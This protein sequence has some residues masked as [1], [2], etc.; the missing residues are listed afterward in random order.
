MPILFPHLGRRSLVAL[1]PAGGIAAEPCSVASG[2]GR[3]FIS[4]SRASLPPGTTVAR[5]PP[6][7]RPCLGTPGCSMCTKT[8]QLHLSKT[9]SSATCPGDGG[10]RPL[11]SPV[12]ASAVEGPSL[13]VPP[14]HRR[15]CCPVALPRLCHG[16]VSLPVSPGLC[17]AVPS[18]PREPGATPCGPKKSHPWGERHK[19]SSWPQFLAWLS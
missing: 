14:W 18:V 5:S 13:G 16:V 12:A 7:P 4:P 1:R 19:E 17:P 15:P 11:S 6:S 3:G 2:H 9:S 8:G 10:A